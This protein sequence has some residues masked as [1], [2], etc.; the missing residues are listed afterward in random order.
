MQPVWR[1]RVG[2]CGDRLA[3]HRR[4]RTRSDMWIGSSVIA[5]SRHFNWEKLEWW[6]PRYH[7][8]ESSDIVIVGVA[9]AADLAEFNQSCKLVELS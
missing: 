1:W 9:R 6:V 3:A 4:D 8:D 5:S 7:M 2:W